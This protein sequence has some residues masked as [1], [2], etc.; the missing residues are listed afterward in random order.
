MPAT[1]VTS[2]QHAVEV[3]L[4]DQSEI[5][6]AGGLPGTLYDLTLINK[7]LANAGLDQVQQ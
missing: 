3:G 1:L 5:D 6:A 7:S 4:L 2:S